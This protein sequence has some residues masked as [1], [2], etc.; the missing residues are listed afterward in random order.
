[1]RTARSLGL[2]FWTPA[3][4]IRQLASHILKGLS[5]RHLLL[6]LAVFLPLLLATFVGCKK[7]TSKAEY[8]YVGA[9][10][11]VLRDRVA[12]VYNKVGSVKNAERVEVLERS[13]HFVR[14]RSPR[15]EEGWMEQRY[16][17]EQTVYD[18]FQKM[19][20]NYASSP[21]QA[22]ATTRAPANMHLAPGRETEKLFQLGDGQRVGL[23]ERAS[24][25]RQVPGGAS[26][27]VV[28]KSTAANKATK[29]GKQTSEAPPVPMEDWWLVR[30]AQKRVGWVLGR[31]LD[32]DVPLEI[33]QYA[34][35]QRIV[36][37]LVLT[38]IEDPSIG[39]ANKKVP[40]Y[41]VL[42]T[43]PRDG[44]PFDFNHIRVFSWNLKRHRYET[45]Y[46]ERNLLGV[47]PVTVGKESFAKEGVLPFFVVRSKDE[48]AQVIE[49]TYKLNG[50]MVRR[51]L[52]PGEQPRKGPANLARRAAQ[53]RR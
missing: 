29:L 23:L 45:A 18:Q 20:R 7:E 15:N 53:G 26:L 30:D 27:P 3:S 33:A 2:N 24:T 51:V 17:V 14:V 22:E 31:I 41:L 40:Y 38:E 6:P 46:R 32:V 48:H 5:H 36:A 10:Q 16:L 47:L 4:V 52:A 42:T 50:V 34:E 43:E 35:G 44:L 39:K 12:A 25:P 49:R 11:V 37:A 13:K 21:A 9:P 28:K 19:A 1:M 8:A